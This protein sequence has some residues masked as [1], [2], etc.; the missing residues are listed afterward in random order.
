MRPAHTS[1]TGS[2]ARPGLPRRHAVV[3]TDR[4]PYQITN[5]PRTTLDAP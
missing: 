3:W 2:I 5:G 4:M 1:S